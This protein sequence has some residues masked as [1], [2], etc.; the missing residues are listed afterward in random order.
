MI[1]TPLLES[2]RDRTGYGRKRLGVQRLTC[3]VQ[4]AVFD[5]WT[6][7]AWLH[8]TVFGPLSEHKRIH[9]PIILHMQTLAMSYGRSLPL[10]PPRWMIRSV[11]LWT[12]YW[13]RAP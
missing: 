9:K 12:R 6:A 13:P 10:W 1:L 3:N 4:E 5:G 11:W 7:S 8:L 2:W